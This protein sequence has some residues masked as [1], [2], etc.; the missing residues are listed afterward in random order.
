[1]ARVP[2]P[3]KKILQRQLE[4]RSRLWPELN[5]ADLWSRHT[6]DGFSTI[7]SALPLI[8]S[9]MDDMSQGG[10][11][12][13]TYLELWTR[14]YDEGF[15]TLSKP[16][17]MA[18]HAGFTTQ[19]AERTWKQKLETLAELSFISLKSGP[20][21]SASYALLL[22]PYTV[23]KH[24]HD[25]KSPGLREDKYNALVARASEIGDTS[26]APPTP[27]APTPPM[28]WPIP[29]TPSIPGSAFPAAPANPFTAGAGIAPAAQFP[30]GGVAGAS[31]TFSPGQLPQA[32]WHATAPTPPKKE[33]A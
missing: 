14:A 29:T 24:H 10:P 31:L 8:M 23:I 26:F 11:V 19:R 13:S 25:H 20:S 1:M 6:H 17:E 5:P 30:A 21:G 4:L 32:A 27:L 9:I 28:P 15:V 33:Q 3:P 7:P 16:R 22:N 12:S 18:F 2:R